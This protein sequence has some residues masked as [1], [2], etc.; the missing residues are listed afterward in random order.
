[1]IDTHTMTA[2]VAASEVRRIRSLEEL[3]AVAD[4]EAA[5]TEF[6]GGRATVLDAIE[7]RRAQLAE[8]E[9]STAR[10]APRWT[11]NE[12]RGHTNY[13]CQEC[14]FATLDR[15]QM[16]KHAAARHPRQWEGA[17]AAEAA[18]PLAGIDFASDEAAQH[19]AR[20]TAAQIKR[21]RAQTPSGKT[22]GYTAADVRVAASTERS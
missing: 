17:A 5:H 19:A 3:E 1:M 4:R 6:E 22:G 20:M 21:L 2:D 9:S 8:E 7:V 11:T 16:V 18:N 10:K 15:G 12:W 13:Q 14:P